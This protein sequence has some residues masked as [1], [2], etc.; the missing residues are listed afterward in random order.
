MLRRLLS[1]YK[2][3]HSGQVERFNHTLVNMLSMF[4]NRYQSDWDK[5]INACQFAYRSAVN[6]ST[7][8]SPFY[9]L[10]GR[11][12]RFPIDA[13]LQRREY[14]DN[15]DDYISRLLQRINVAQDIARANLLERKE[16]LEAGL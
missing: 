11:E 2:P 13:M 6:S 1:P 8:Y 10:H 9:L 16:K 4:V 7:S 15:K 3:Q 14:Y 5:H 12:P